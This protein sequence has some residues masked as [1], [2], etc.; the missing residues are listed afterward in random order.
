M[1]L[2]PSNELG[3]SIHEEITHRLAKDIRIT[4]VFD[5]AFFQMGTN[6]RSNA[7]KHTKECG[8]KH[9]RIYWLV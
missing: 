7:Y 9:A 3:N 4:M 2:N 6:F 5:I 8:G 1:H